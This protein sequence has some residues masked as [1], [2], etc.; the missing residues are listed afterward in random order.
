M[1]VPLLQAAIVSLRGKV[2]KCVWLDF[3]CD[4]G[5]QRLKARLIVVAVAASLKRCPDTN[6]AVSGAALHR[7]FGGA[8]I[9]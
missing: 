4:Y 9:G 3:S 8:G 7:A 5:Q 2:H 1:H 6:R